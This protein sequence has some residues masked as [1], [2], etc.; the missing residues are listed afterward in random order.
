MPKIGGGAE[1]GSNAKMEHLPVLE[2]AVSRIVRKKVC[3]YLNGMQL[4]IEAGLFQG[5]QQVFHIHV[6][7]VAPLCA[8]HITEPCTDQHEGGIPIWKGPHHFCPSSLKCTDKSG[9]DGLQA[10]K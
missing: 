6:L 1:Y 3:R 2:Q 8:S 5:S 9:L 4:A 7:L 10:G